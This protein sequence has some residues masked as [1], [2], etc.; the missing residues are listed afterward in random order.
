L[1][2][3][4]CP[5]LQS[6]AQGFVR[7]RQWQLYSERGLVGAA[8]AVWLFGE[9]LPVKYAAEALAQHQQRD[10]ECEHSIAQG[11]DPDRVF[12]RPPVPDAC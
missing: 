3:T 9:T 11:F 7:F 1:F 10:R 8:A 12:F 5:A 6:D 2:A 4:P